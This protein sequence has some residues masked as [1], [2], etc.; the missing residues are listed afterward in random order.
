VSPAGSVRS[1]DL[2]LFDDA[3]ADARGDPLDQLALQEAQLGRP[4]R[5][6]RLDRQ[7]PVTESDRCRVLGDVLTY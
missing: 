3:V 5:R 2:E 7:F 1:L 6:R 4:R